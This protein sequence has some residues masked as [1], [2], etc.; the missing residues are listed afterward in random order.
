[1]GGRK[2]PVRKLS[3]R[4]Q[5]QRH[6]RVPARRL[7][8]HPPL[9]YAGQLTQPSRCKRRY[10]APREPLKR[11]A[12]GEEDD[13]KTADHLR[14]TILARSG[15]RRTPTW[16]RTALLGLGVDVQ[17]IPAAGVGLDPNAGNP[18]AEFGGLMSWLLGDA[19]ARSCRA[20]TRRRRQKHKVRRGP[21]P[22]AADNLPGDGTQ[23]ENL[24]WKVHLEEALA[25]LTSPKRTSPPTTSRK[26]KWMLL[27]YLEERADTQS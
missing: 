26:T 1:M 8:V 7:R 21:P 15:G 13:R 5:P 25:G 11:W 23:T 10:Q 20:S 16:A 2:S 6:R 3:R 17:Q 19:R 18:W 4:F 9:V 24:K 12:I 22:A 27:H 14:T